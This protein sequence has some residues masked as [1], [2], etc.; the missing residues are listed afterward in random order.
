MKKL[1]GFIIVSA[2]F[3][4]ILIIFFVYQGNTENKRDKYEKF[5]L[6]QAYKFQQIQNNNSKKFD[7]PEQAAFQDFLMTL[8]PKLGR[9]PKER[10]YKAYL[11]TKQF[12]PKTED[13]I[14]E[15]IPVEMGGRSRTLM[16]DPNDAS[17]NKVW[18]G[19]VTGGLWYN[20]NITDAGSAWHPVNDFWQSLSVGSIAYDPN[21][22]QIFYVGTGEPETA[23][24]T[25]RESSG[26][27]IGIMKSTDGGESW[28]L[29]S[30][31]SGFKYITGIAVRNENGTSVIYA[32]VVSGVYQGD[33]QQSIPNDGLYR[34]ADGG[35]TWTQVLPNIPGE[36]VPYSPSDIEITADGRIF[37]GT[38]PNL[39]EKGAAT[40]L[41][42]DTGLNGSWTTYNDYVSI[43]LN[44]TSDTYNIPGRVKLAAAP[45]D[46]NIIYAAIASGSDT[47][48]VE[49]FRKWV[50]NYIIRSDNKGVTWNE[51]NIPEDGWAY[52]AWHALVLKVDPTAPDSLYAGGLDLYKSSDGS[53]SW[54]HISDWSAMY[55]GGGDD[56]VHADQHKIAFKPGNSDEIV[57]ATDGGVFYT[58]NGTNDYPVFKQRNLNLNTLQT[59]TCAI[60]PEE[61]STDFLAGLQDNGTVV[62]TNDA[63]VTVFNM[64]DGGDGAYCFYDEDEPNISITSYYDNRYTFFNNYEYV[65]DGG[66]YSG[67]FVSP[68][69]YDSRFNKL[70]AN[71]VTFTGQNQN[72]ILRI[73]YIP[74]NPANHIVSVGTDSNVAF[75]CVRVSPHSPDN[76]TTLFLGTM[77]GRL[78]KTEHAGTVPTSVELTG[79]TF[80]IAAISS[81][82]FGESEDFIL[83]TFSNYGVSSVWLTEDGG[84]TW[85]EKEGNLPDIP[86][87]WSVIHHQDNNMVM[88]ATELGVWT[89]NDIYADNVVWSQAINGM[90]NVR[91][92]MLDMRNCDNAILAGTHGRGF[93]LSHYRAFPEIVN[94]QE[95]EKIKV[96]PNPSKGIFNINSYS[97]TE[98]KY[99]IY[100]ILGH[101]IKKGLLKNAFETI[102]LTNKKSG[103]YFLKIDNQ[104]IKIT[105][106]K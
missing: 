1:S 38:M 101:I 74:N 12:A 20:N 60:K 69:D 81:I 88:L 15:N 8:D 24:T 34:S 71:A 64:I 40:I 84:N 93:F 61:S 14:W 100:D 104:T 55:Y 106:I 9:V 86:V 37:V 72:K 41:F 11:Q 21:N 28:N 82:S 102:N 30:S 51:K 94:I 52:L 77:S 6:S 49:S 54:A 105:V 32:G 23:V 33:V 4:G 18:T 31:S 58:S 53:N 73:D 10:L 76:S 95:K 35:N 19:S 3:S 17:G 70:F 62:H 91:I 5:L 85:S 46:A 97:D 13:I 36:N 96:F 68:A 103:N 48:T 98:K 83:V 50:C 16:W 63:P 66:Q 99:E 56:Y 65:G 78:F 45:S 43:I 90:A 57:F 27:G 29:L 22:T 44:N 79:T 39:N 92:D 2:L 87:R 26:I 89:T 7:K 80:P 42:S 47:E 25:Y 67:T 75:S 59:Y